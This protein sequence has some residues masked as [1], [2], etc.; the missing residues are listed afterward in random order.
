MYIHIWDIYMYMYIE[1]VY[2][3]MGSPQSISKSKNL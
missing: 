3:Y 2:I 1:D